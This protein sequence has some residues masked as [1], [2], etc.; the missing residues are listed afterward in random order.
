MSISLQKEKIKRENEKENVY[1]LNVGNCM[2]FQSIHN[3]ELFVRE[4]RINTEEVKN[5]CR[6]WR[7]KNVKNQY[8][9]VFGETYDININMTMHTK[10]KCL[11]L[12]L[13]KAIPYRNSRTRKRKDAKFVRGINSRARERNPYIREF[14]HIH[15]REYLQY[16]YIAIVYSPLCEH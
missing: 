4:Y 9:C 5:A 2:G 11:W 12:E 6:Q 15:K 13:T 14:S 1:I 8:E 7:F 10:E 16:E 3:S